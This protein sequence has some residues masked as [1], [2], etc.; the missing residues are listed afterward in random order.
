MKPFAARERRLLEPVK[1]IHRS[2]A[3][4]LR[5]LLFFAKSNDSP[6]SA[7]AIINI[8]LI[9]RSGARAG[10]SSRPR[11]RQSC[12]CFRAGANKKFP[13]PRGPR[14]TQQV[15]GEEAGCRGP[16]AGRVGIYTG[17][18]RGLSDGQDQR[19]AIFRAGD[20]AEMRPGDRCRYSARGRS[21]ERPAVAL[22]RIALQRIR[23]SSHQNTAAILI[24]RAGAYERLLLHTARSLSSQI[25]IEK[26]CVSPYQSKTDVKQSKGCHIHDSRVLS[27]T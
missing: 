5:R 21:G 10:L 7:C 14:P 17:A 26:L 9:G 24:R 12:C 8:R 11:R 20:S 25:K 4:F 13:P 22:L 18:N 23:A 16:S 2:S 6:G 19:I 15:A 27:C 1:K 3:D